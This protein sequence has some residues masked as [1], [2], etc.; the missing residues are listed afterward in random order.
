MAQVAFIRRFLQDPGIDV[1]LE[2]ESVN[3]LDLDPP[4]FVPGVGTGTVCVVGEFENGPFNEPTEILSASDMQLTFGGFGYNYPGDSN[5]NACAVKRQADGGTAEPWNGNGPV[6]MNG[7]RFRR[8]ILVRA[9]TST[10]SVQFTRLA[11]L[12]GATV[13]RFNLEPGENV[14]FEDGT[15]PDTATFNAAAATV[16]SGAGTYATGFVGGETLVLGYDQ[17]SNFTVTFLATDQSHAQVIDRIN[18]YAGYTMA[19]I[20]APTITTL[21]GRIRGTLG[22]VRVVSASAGVL[23]VLGLTAATTNGTGNVANIDAVQ[24]SEVDTIVSAAT[25]G[26]IRAYLDDNGALRLQ[27]SSNSFYV[28]SATATGL[29]LTANL[30]STADSDQATLIS[31]AGT[32]PTGFLGGETLVLGSGDNPNITITFLVADQSQ[33][34][35]ISRIN[36]GMGYTCAS[37]FTATRT[38]LVS[39]NGGEELRIVGGS[40]SVLTALGLAAK[41]ITPQTNADFTLLAGTR[42]RVPSGSRFVTMQDVSITADSDGPYDVKV[43]PAVDDGTSTGALAGTVTEV[44]SQPA[45]ASFSV[46]NLTP[47]SAALSENAIDNAY[48]TALDATLDVNSVSKDINIIYSARQSN[49]VRAK[50]KANV[51]F[52]SANGLSGRCA[53]VR[54]PL[55]T[56][57]AVAKS[58]AA[59][60]GVGA[61]RDERVF[62]CYPQ[63]ATYVPPIALKGVAGGYGFTANGVVDVGADGFLASVL[64]QLAPEENP[65]QS[66]PYLDAVVSLE[67][68]PNAKGFTIDDYKAFKAAGIIAGNMSGASAFFQSG[69]TSSLQP[70]RTTIARRRMADYIQDSLARRGADYSKKLNRPS[71]RNAYVSEIINF[72][73]GLKSETNPEAKRI[74]DYS[75]DAKSGN[76]PT[77][78]ARGLFRILL[79]CRT[80]SSID[81]IALQSTIGEGVVIVSE[82]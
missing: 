4:G 66:N 71:N 82:Q 7:K 18:Q 39:Q 53:C 28:V 3:I 31:S 45:N 23:A 40:A 72:M 1:L 34:Q 79:N 52:A 21:V 80:L 35:V 54:T 69:V 73:D 9:D 11:F 75:L 32:F 10:G 47:V 50:L 6:Q 14:I 33:A 42:V 46:I 30:S 61:T 78:L 13:F 57:K 55:G 41:T 49:A 51:V 36:A 37:S 8:T 19:S 22:N 2:I 24:I 63:F 64:S 26:N 65:G 12:S 56:T 15:G 43:R 27:T 60:P 17:Q 48:L 74:E 68:S 5:A 70:G 29:G 44:E 16:A 62:Y 67:S 25:S 20:S 38:K 76:T 77:L 59:A 81:A 58:N